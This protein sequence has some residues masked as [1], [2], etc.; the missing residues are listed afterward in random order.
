[1]SIIA[2][3]VDGV[4]ADFSVAY[5]KLII[6]T[7]GRDIF[8]PIKA[9]VLIDSQMTCWDWPESYGYTRD[10][11]G[12]VWKHI[13][14]DQCFWQFLPP[15]PTA[16]EFLFNLNHSSHEVY[17]VT[18]RKGPNAQFQTAAWLSK[19]GYSNHPAVILAP[20]GKANILGALAADFFIDDKPDTLVSVMD[21]LPEIATFAIDYPYN[22]HIELP[23][24]RRLH[25]VMEFWEAIN[26]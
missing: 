8:P 6:E 23:V 13:G 7:T 18:N 22:S 15:L 5:R 10:E 21:A 4:L 20:R 24:T 14:S 1:M 2:V 11:I 9:G 25:D 17:F 12:K 3:D 19:H 16:V 26:G